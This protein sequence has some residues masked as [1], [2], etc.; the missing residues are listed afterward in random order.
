MD[1]INNQLDELLRNNERF[2]KEAKRRRDDER[3]ILFEKNE[4]KKENPTKVRQVKKDD[5]FTKQI[6]RRA[7]YSL[8]IFIYEGEKVNTLYIYSLIKSSSKWNKIE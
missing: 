8:N 6:I 4:S 3:K 7:H 5:C 2:M 1:V